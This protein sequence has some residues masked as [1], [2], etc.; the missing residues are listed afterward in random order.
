MGAVPRRDLPR[1]A[2]PGRCA[3]S[4]RFRDMETPEQQYARR[5][6]VPLAQRS[7]QAAGKHAA[8]AV[9]YDNRAVIYG[10]EGKPYA[11]HASSAEAARKSAWHSAQAARHMADAERHEATAKPPAPKKRWW[12]S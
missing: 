8:D 10:R 11:D 6:A 9:D 2:P 12:Q 1:H 4:R 3:V 5:Q 7:R